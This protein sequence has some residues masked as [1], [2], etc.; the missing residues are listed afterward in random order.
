MLD[1]FPVLIEFGLQVLVEEASGRAV[2][3]ATFEHEEVVL[4]SDATL[5][6]VW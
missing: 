4:V 3:T 1:H 6:E 5:P 2:V